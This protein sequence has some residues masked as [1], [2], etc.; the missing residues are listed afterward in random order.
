MIARRKANGLAA[1]LKA[2]KRHKVLAAQE[3][4]KHVSSRLALRRLA[5]TG[6]ISS[7]GNGLYASPALDPF[8]ASVVAVARYYP[9]T[10][11]SGLTAMVIHELSEE[12]IDRID[13]DVERGRSIRNKMVNCHRVPK[14][15]LIG[16][17]T[18]KYRNEPIRVYDK[19]RTLC[20]AYRLD[21]GG[22]LFFKALKRYLRQQRP[23]TDRLQ[24]YDRKLKT[25]VIGHLQQEL[26][27]A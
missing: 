21:P 6:Q 12:R 2:L 22:P 16:I 27:D 4:E 5:D 26:A 3:L 8:V 19:E 23:N 25:K 11:V 15:R 9:D 14:S 10:V 20:E 18:M 1:V 7:L 17:V 13:V 24:E